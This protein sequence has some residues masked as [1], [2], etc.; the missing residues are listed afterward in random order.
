MDGQ[1]V[2]TIVSPYVGLEPPENIRL[3]AK[4]VDGTN[5]HVRGWLME[6]RFCATYRLAVT[7]LHRQAA[8]HQ[9]VYGIYSWT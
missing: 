8:S 1:T 7:E 2:G 5:R 4:Q 9:N 6:Y 3:V